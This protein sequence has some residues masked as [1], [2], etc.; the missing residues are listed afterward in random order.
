VRAETA[1][2]LREAVEVGDVEPLTPAQIEI[3]VRLVTAT[4]DGIGLQWLLDPS[5]DVVAS[6]TTYIDR[7]IAAWNGQR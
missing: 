2:H 6:V 7:A 4:L 3:E 1:S 5:T